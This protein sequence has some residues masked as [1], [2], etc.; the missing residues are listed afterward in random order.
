MTRNS[1]IPILT[2]LTV[3]AAAIAFLFW[4]I[5]FRQPSDSLRH[6]YGD[7]LP[8]FNASMNAL[9]AFSL[10]CGYFAIRRLDHRRHG[11]CMLAAFFFSTLFLFGYIAYYVTHGN[12]KFLAQGWIRPIYFST[13]ISHILLSL[14]ALPLVLCM[15]YF[16]W[17]KKWPQHRKLAYFTLP[18]WFYVSVTGVLVFFLQRIFNVAS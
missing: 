17:A 5:Y 15:F 6:A 12:T 14:P 4:I 2:I 10:V 13:L 18:I 7:M 3:S 11:R 9:S 16:A 8:A 1:W